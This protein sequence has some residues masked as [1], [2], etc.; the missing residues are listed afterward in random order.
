MKLCTNIF[1]ILLLSQYNLIGQTATITGVVFDEQN[2]PLSNVN[3][4][5]TSEGTF[6]DSDGFYALQ[7]TAD[8]ETKITFSH[9]GHKEVIL[10]NLILNTN[11]TYEFNPVMRTDAIQIDEVTD[12]YR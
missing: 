8:T 5:S 6:S 7:L 2:N 12:P 1:F 11:E 4:S 10:E 3:I 9:I